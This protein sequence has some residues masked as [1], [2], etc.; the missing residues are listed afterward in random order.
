VIAPVGRPT[1]RLA[2]ILAFGKPKVRRGRF[3]LRIN[4]AETA[5]SGIALIEVFRGKRKIG[6]ARVRVRRGGSRRVV[7]KLTSTGKR[8]LRR[9]KSKRLRVKVQVRVKRQVL[10]SRTLTLRR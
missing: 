8:L 4:F 5:P 7:V 2:T 9:S 1:A 10:R 6:G 3:H